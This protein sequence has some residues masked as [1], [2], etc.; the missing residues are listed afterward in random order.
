MYSHKLLFLFEIFIEIILIASI[1]FI[2]SQIFHIFLLIILI[3][4]YSSIIYCFDV[5]DDTKISEYD[6]KVI[7]FIFTFPMSIIGVPLYFAVTEF[8]DIRI[9]NDTEIKYQNRITIFDFFIKSVGI[10]TMVCVIF[11]AFLYFGIHPDIDGFNG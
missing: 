4:L 8:S 9:N 3:S 1:F 7:T 2:K 6:Y 11:Y 10:F 5:F